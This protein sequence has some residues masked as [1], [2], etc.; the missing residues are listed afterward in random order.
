MIKLLNR[1]TGT[2]MWVTEERLDDYL[3]AGH[4]LAAMSASPEVP[5]EPTIT[6]L[7]EPVKKSAKRRRKK[8]VG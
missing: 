5:A 4:K 3:A 1:L 8:E 7:A 2:I 6:E